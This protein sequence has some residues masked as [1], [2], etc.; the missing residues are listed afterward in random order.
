MS[1]KINSFVFMLEVYTYSIVVSAQML[2]LVW[3]PW[4]MCRNG[5]K[6]SKF[7]TKSFNAERNAK[8]S[9]PSS[10]ILAV[11]K[12]AGSKKYLLTIGNN[13]TSQELLSREKRKKFSSLSY[14]RFIEDDW[15]TYVL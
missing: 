6:N 3:I 12:S 15:H 14:M 1:T 11:W 10:Q 9:I 5:G 7:F 4:V 8:K 2:N 13:A